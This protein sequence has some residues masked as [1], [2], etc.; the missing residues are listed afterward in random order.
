M[1][2]NNTY[3][4]FSVKYIHYIITRFD[5]RRHLKYDVYKHT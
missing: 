2:E 5:S 4:R 3:F 1:Y